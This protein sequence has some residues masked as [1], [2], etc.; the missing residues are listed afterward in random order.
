M[1][2]SIVDGEPRFTE[3][4]VDRAARG[5]MWWR[6]ALRV[7]NPVTRYR[8]LWSGARHW[9]L[10]AVGLADH[11]V[12][13]D[14]DFRLVAHPAPPAWARDAIVY[15]IFPD[16]FARSAAADRAGAGLGDPVRLG[17]ASRR[18]RTRDTAG[19]STAATSTAS[20]ATSTTSPTWAPTPSI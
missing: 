3:A 6:A 14:T 2:R 10:T 8:F 17:H 16:R 11:D 12:P 15:Q 20:A 7:H 4:V 19:R 13:D 18:P 5:E 1:R 9:W